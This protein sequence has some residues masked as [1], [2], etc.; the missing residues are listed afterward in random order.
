[1]NPADFAP[2]DAALRE[3]IV[4]RVGGAPYPRLLGLRYEDLRRDYARMRLPHRREVEQDAGIVHGGAIASLIDSVVV[5]AVLSGID[6][7][8]RRLVT[9]D[10]HVA[11]LD[12]VAGEDVVAEARVRR[13]GRSIVFVEAEARTD[14]G[15]DVAHGEIIYR[16]FALR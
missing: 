15:R 7:P 6:G 3:V 16:V 2:I 9:V 14:G 5:A 10:M 4:S 12:A 11:Y 8:P 13:R 1:M